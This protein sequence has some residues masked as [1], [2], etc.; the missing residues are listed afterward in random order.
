M[1]ARNSK[2]WRA[3]ALRASIHLGTA[4]LLLDMILDDAPEEP[5]AGKLR[6]IQGEVHATQDLVRELAGGAQ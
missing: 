1:T 2:L 3:L 5:L 6:S 4:R